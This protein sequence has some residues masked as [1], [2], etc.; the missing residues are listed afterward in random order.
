MRFRILLLL[1]AGLLLAVV[2]SQLRGAVLRN[3]GAIHFAH[4]ALGSEARN[5]GHLNQSLRYF[6][7]ML[8]QPLD[9]SASEQ[10]PFL[11]ELLQRYFSEVGQETVAIS[12]A[13]SE[14]AAE[15]AMVGISYKPV[16]FERSA[17]V[18]VR[19]ALRMPVT[20]AGDCEV[21]WSQVHHVTNLAWVGEDIN[22]IEKTGLSGYSS[23]KKTDM[24]RDISRNRVQTVERNGRT[25]SVFVLEN[26]VE[27][28]NILMSHPIF[29][30][31]GGTYYIGAWTR[32][33]LGMPNGTLTVVCSQ[34]G[35][36]EQYFTVAR[37][38]SHRE[39]MYAFGSFT[40]P[41]NMRACRI[42]LLN[43]GVPETVYF[44]DLFLAELV[45]AEQ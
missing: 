38:F 7:A 17:E 13:A 36:K 31:P 15:S 41:E 4:F 21:V 26:L 35:M 22:R 34:F 18:P 45:S 14:C 39:W 24:L 44:D 10:V 27:V 6:E 12:A 19:I 1:S 42:L 25:A 33:D 32:T 5:L 3:L 2:A 11:R 20:D 16:D 29:F 8:E 37:K 43:Y 30:R 23:G 40:V 28:D 9:T